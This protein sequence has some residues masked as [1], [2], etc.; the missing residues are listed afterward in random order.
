MLGFN[1]SCST[2]LASLPF[3]RIRSARCM[4]LPEDLWRE[5]FVRL[6]CVITERLFRAGPLFFL[7]LFDLRTS[8][9]VCCC[10]FWRSRSVSV[11]RRRQFLVRRRPYAMGAL[12]GEATPPLW[13]SAGWAKRRNKIHA[14]AVG[15]RLWAM[16]F[17][18]GPTACVL[19]HAS[20]AC[21]SP[22]NVF[23]TLK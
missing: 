15:N 4:R 20:R 23:E 9:L 14:S 16:T 6:R 1:W 13:G 2:N 10:C 5:A 12:E 22:R 11:L 7:L 18:F 8:A 17:N 21:F 3:L 19:E